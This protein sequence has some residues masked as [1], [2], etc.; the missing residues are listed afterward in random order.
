MIDDGVV[1]D[2]LSNCLPKASG[3]RSR[4]KLKPS[5]TTRRVVVVVVVVVVAFPMF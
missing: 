5:C 2:R 1:D 3:W 4:Q